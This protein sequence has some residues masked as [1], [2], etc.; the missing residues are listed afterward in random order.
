MLNDGDIMSK[1]DKDMFKINK[2]EV[3]C[4]WGGE[5]EG[6]IGLLQIRV[7]IARGRSSVQT[8]FGSFRPSDIFV[9]FAAKM[10][11]T[12]TSCNYKYILKHNKGGYSYFFNKIGNAGI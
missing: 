8:Y 4:V 5:E 1:Q 7:C 6:G 11:A 12:R 10:A 2:R 9:F 3:V